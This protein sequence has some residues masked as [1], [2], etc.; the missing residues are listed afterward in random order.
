MWNGKK[1]IGKTKNESQKTNQYIHCIIL[2]ESPTKLLELQKIFDA[3]LNSILTQWRFVMN[4]LAKLIFILKW[5]GF[6]FGIESSSKL[7]YTALLLHQIHTWILFFG[8]TLR[9]FSHAR[10]HISSENDRISQCH[11][12]DNEDVK[13]YAQWNL[14]YSPP[15]IDADPSSSHSNINSRRFVDALPSFAR[16]GCVSCII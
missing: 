6:Y 13:M 9:A 10:V 15:C 5:K 3:N 16:R 1:K 14:H 4:N 7:G 2:V 12:G 11:W 8:A